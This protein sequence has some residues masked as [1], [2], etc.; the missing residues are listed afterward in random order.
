MSVINLSSNKITKEDCILEIP[1]V[2]YDKNKLLEIYEQ[3]K[4]YARVKYLP[5]RETPKEFIQKDNSKALVIQH[6]DNEIRNPNEFGKGANLLEFSYIRE[7]TER[8]NFNRKIVSSDIS[9]IV[10]KDG[11]TFKPHADGHAACVVMFP[12]IV[13]SYIDFYHE[14]NMVFESYKEYD[15]MDY[16]KIV[17]SHYYNETY[18]TIFNSHVIHGVKPTKGFQVKLKINMNEQFHSVREKYKNGTLVSMS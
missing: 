16:D 10:Y 1:E 7:L 15:K 9:M 18:A 6:T 5:W 4:D 17:H 11:F 3:V 12:I 2:S 13:S 8:F 14:S